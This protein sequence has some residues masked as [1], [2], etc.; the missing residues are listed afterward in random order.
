[1]KACIPAALFVIASTLHAEDELLRI[2]PRVVNTKPVPVEQRE[3]LLGGCS[4]YC[5]APDIAVSASSFLS[6]KSGLE[7][8]AQFAHDFKLSTVWAEGTRGDGVGESL[9]FTFRTT[10][11]DTKNLSVTSIT[12][13][14]GY[15]ASKRLFFQNGRPRT[16]RLLYDDRPVALLVLQDVMGSQTFDIPKLA[17]ARP[18]T[19]RIKLQILDIFPG[20]KFRDTCITDVIFSGEGDMH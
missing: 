5:G 10:A 18:S 15:Q 7:H 9:D 8:S 6:E 4:W 12:I 1:M 16:L 3:S 19:H 11:E 2:T 20:R 13:L 17:L 14:P